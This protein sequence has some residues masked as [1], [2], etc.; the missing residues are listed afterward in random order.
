ML[1]GL[2]VRSV[3]KD[4]EWEECSQQECIGLKPLW[5]ISMAVSYKVWHAFYKWPNNY[6]P[7][8]MNH[9]NMMTK[10]QQAYK[11]QKTKH[12]RVHTVW[13]HWYVTLGKTNLIY[14]DRKWISVCLGPGVLERKW[15]EKVTGQV[16]IVTEAFNTLVVALIT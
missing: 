12:T 7:K 10:S 11:E 2:I 15:R 3:G 9:R 8:Y 16:F 6:T 5:K 4:V 14:S 13:S 1:K